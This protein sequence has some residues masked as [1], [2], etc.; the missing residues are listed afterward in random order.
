MAGQKRTPW[1]ERAA[2]VKTAYP[3]STEIDWYSVF[4]EDPAILGLII[5]DIYKLDQSRSGKPGKRPSLTEDSTADKLKKMHG[6]DY[7]EK[8]F[9]EAFKALCGDRSVR[10]VASKIQ[11]DKSYV[12]RLLTGAAFPPVET[13]AVIAK[14]FNKDPSY[15]LEYRIHM[16]LGALEQ[17]LQEFPESSVV[18]YNKIYGRIEKN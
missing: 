2:A 11:L 8:G 13:M 5:N 12:H 3:L 6:L 18:F 15:F 7:T 17:K 16:V 1:A 9:V 14:S 10:A 4:S